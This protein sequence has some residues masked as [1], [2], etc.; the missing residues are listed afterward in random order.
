MIK[1]LMEMAQKAE[2]SKGL[3]STLRWKKFTKKKHEMLFDMNKRYGVT[4]E[5]YRFLKALVETIQENPNRNHYSI[6]FL[7]LKGSPLQN[8]VSENPERSREVMEGIKSYT[9]FT[10]IHIRLDSWD[11]SIFIR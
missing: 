1:E 9:L 6:F 5:Y 10:D 4:N 11:A 8:W 7:D 2:A 3:I